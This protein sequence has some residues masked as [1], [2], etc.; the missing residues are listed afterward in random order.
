MRLW[1]S[2]RN[3][4]LKVRDANGIVRYGSRSDGRLVRG[5]VMPEMC[6]RGEGLRGEFREED[7]DITLLI[8]FW[9]QSQSSLGSAGWSWRARAWLP[10]VDDT[11][12]HVVRYGVRVQRQGTAIWRDSKAGRTVRR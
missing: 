2:N 6:V 12:R 10:N 5:D 11:A 8:L 1:L 7:T 9:R 4:V 3:L